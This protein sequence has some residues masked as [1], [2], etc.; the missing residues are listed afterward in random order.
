MDSQ[1]LTHC[2]YCFYFLILLY[3]ISIY[4]KL[5]L[6]YCIVSAAPSVPI[7]IHNFIYGIYLTDISYVW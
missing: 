5:I 2:P 4:L 1:L 6:L 3:C 7:K